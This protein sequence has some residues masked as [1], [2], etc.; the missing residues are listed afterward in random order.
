MQGIV[1]LG[2]TGSI[3][4]KALEVIAWY[5]EQYQVIALV[6]NRNIDEIFIQCKQA[7]PRYVVV[8]EKQAASILQNRLRQHHLNT[9]EVYSG[10][11]AIK[12]ILSLSEVQ[13]VVAAITGRAGLVPTL[14]AISAGKRVLLANKESLVMA[15]ALIK[16]ALITHHAEVIPIDSEHHALFQCLQTYQVGNASPKGVKKMILTASGGPFR[17]WEKTALNQVTPEQACLHPIW[18]MG[19]KI[20]V[21]SATLMNKG[22]EVIEAHWLF[23]M[24]PEKIDVLIHPQSIVHALLQYESGALIAQLSKPDMLV[25]IASAFNW[26]H[27]LS[28]PFESLDLVKVAQ[29]TFEAVDYLRF[30][31]LRLAYQALEMGSGATVVLNAANEVAVHCFLQGKIGFMDIPKMITFVLEKMDA[32]SANDLDT[33]LSIDH[34]ARQEAMRWIHV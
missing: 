4:K 8:Q 19:R 13:V 21:D 25:P 1:I 23:A 15:G 31:C 28:I 30:P 24:A 10:E 14:A 22:L 18:S 11:D 6:A 32:P 5:P 26:P 17:T 33:V 27:H 9:I 34:L 2:S 29:L 3:G 12:N 7:R 20:S 16:K